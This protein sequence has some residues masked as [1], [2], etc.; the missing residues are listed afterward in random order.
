MDLEIVK[1]LQ[2]LRN[3]VL[4]WFF[5]IVTQIGDQ[6]V[7]IAIAVIIYWTIDKKYAHMFVFAF[8]TS[9]IVN[10]SLKEIF[11]R[12]RPFYLEGVESEDHWNTDGYSFPSGHAQAAGVLGYTAFDASKKTK[13]NWIWYVGIAIMVL[14]PLS[15][16]YLGQ[17][18]LSDV[19]VGVTLA[20]FISHFTFKLVRTMKDKEHIYT[21]MLIPLFVIL[22]FFVKNHDL[23]IAAG[24]F[25]GFA[26]GY[27]IEKVYVKYDV[28][29]TFWK[30]VL[31]LV[32]GLVIVLVIKEGLKFILPYSAL[33]ETDPTTLDLFLDFFR[34]LMIGVWAAAGA[35]WV[36]K[37]VIKHR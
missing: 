26:S 34:Y 28:K 13:K 3:P 23:Y 24:G 22:L 10:S 19:L 32:I 18:Y 7:F 4:D 25:I 8:M 20:F 15:R 33:E 12:Q 36:F 6:Y 16:V 37:H 31:K 2:L 1:A 27:Y 17:H 5:Y 30:Q 35:P 14:V 21:I 9:A 11:K 29:T